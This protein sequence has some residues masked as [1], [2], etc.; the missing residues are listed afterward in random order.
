MLIS[1]IVLTLFTQAPAPATQPGDAPATDPRAEGLRLIEGLPDI[2]LGLVR[3]SFLEARSG[4]KPNGMSRGRL[5]PE[6]AGDGSRYYAYENVSLMRGQDGQTIEVITSG[7]LDRWFCPIELNWTVRRYTTDRKVRVS[8][9]QLRVTDKQIL[10]TKHPD[11]GEPTEIKRARPEGRFIYLTGDLLCLLD[12]K[13]DRVFILRELDPESGKVVAQTYRT[14]EKE[15]GRL[16]IGL[17]RLPGKVET[18][19]FV[20]DRDNHIGL[21]EVHGTPIRFY[22]TDAVRINAIESALRRY[23]PIPPKL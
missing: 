6:E 22:R 20:R 5:E 1:A 8:R 17:T 9:E 7:K 11:E 12:L 10:L 18:E 19:V 2:K 21:H 16:R 13:P 3:H 15:D 4:D 23:L 14:R